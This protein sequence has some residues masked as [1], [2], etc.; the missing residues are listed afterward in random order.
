[1]KA[2]APS[3]AAIAAFEWRTATRRLPFAAAALLMGLMGFA[4]SATAFGPPELLLNGAWSV[5]SSVGFLTLVSVFAA[6]LLT[7]PVLLR[8]EE[9]RMAEIVYTTAVTKRGYLLGRFAGALLATAT[10]VLVGV[11]G[12]AAG[13]F[14][15]PHDPARLAPF[16][17][18]PYLWAFAVLALP[19]VLLVSACL[20]AVAALTRSTPATYV[21][22]VLL[23]LLYFV[24]ALLADSP[25]LAGSGPQSAGAASLAALL[26]PFGLS[27]FLSDTRFWTVAERNERLV[28]LAGTFLGSRLVGLGA[29]G[30][31][32]TVAYRRFAF[33]LAPGAGRV[34]ADAGPE[35]SDGPRAPSPGAVTTTPGLAAFGSTL[36]VELRALFRSAPLAALFALWIGYLAIETVQSFRSNELGTAVIPTAGLLVADVATALNVLGILFLVFFA[37]ETAWRERLVRVSEVVDATPASSALVLLGK[38]GALSAVLVAL[39]ASGLATALAFQAVVGRFE[40]APLTWAALLPVA[41]LPLVLLAL[42]VLLVQALVPNRH[43]GLALSVALIAFLHEGALGGPDHPLLRYAYAPR[44]TWS[45]LS[46]LSP[47]AESL[48]WF[49]AF[50]S[51]VAALLGVVTFGLW[52]RGTD[53]RLAPRLAALPRRWGRGGRLGAIA[54]ATL[55]LAVGGFAFHGT[56]VANRYETEA[57]L[58]AWKAAYERSYRPIEARAQP[59]PAHLDA[60][61]DLEPEARRLRVRGRLRLENRTPAA[62]DSVWVAARRDV[63]VASMTL[64]GAVPSDVDE[65]FATRRFAL[66]SPM[67]PG[68]ALDLAFDLLLER[69]SPSAADDADLVPN[70]TYV[71]GLAALPT[72]G[73]R[74]SWE[75]SDP[76]A[77]RRA[78]L[79]ERAVDDDPDAHLPESPSRMTFDV[80]VTTPA[81]QHAVA[82]GA[83]VSSTVAG[84]RRTSRFRAAR[85]VSAYFAFAS[86]RYHVERVRHV[87]VDVEVYVHP[88]HRRNVARVLEAAT[89]T[90][91]LCVARYG[92]Y[93][94]PQLRIAEVPDASLRA[95]GFALPGVV[96]LAERRGFLIDA[97]APGRV[98]L[99]AKRVAHEVS[100]Q[101]WGH[102]LDPAS[103]P[104]ATALVESLARHTELRV[105]KS[106]RGAEALRPVLDHE[107]DRYLT[108][109]TAGGEVPLVE[110]GR[111]PWLYYAKGSL[112]M[113]AISELAGEEA[114]D[115]ALGGL[116]A[117]AETTGRAP[118]ARDLV[119]RLLAATPAADRPLVEEWWTRSVLHDLRITE[120][121]ATRLPDGRYRVDVAVDGRTV[122]A[123][124]GAEKERPFGGDVELVVR[125]ARSDGGDDEAPP[126]HSARH[127]VRGPARLSVLVDGR[128]GEVLLDP[129]RLLLDRDRADDARDVE[130]RR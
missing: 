28:P 123:T 13:T 14:L 108:G 62:I 21:A 113:A 4:L 85:P 5:T 100:H 22:G 30:L 120:A 39:A 60:A 98:D 35:R 1:M 52:P 69:R 107:L 6:I 31:A 105:L 130:T 63:R 29:A 26:D 15:V 72:I 53:P 99:L 19:G 33:R 67:A 46:G 129:R 40:L 8:D 57:D 89:R 48:G 23:Y 86:A 3:A 84:D 114:V 27:A 77:R 91:D 51:A 50:W 71:H 124:E 115:G 88:G 43:V 37:A 87:G 24:A 76:A 16:A 61:F 128:P 93:P 81:N 104:G 92:P 118:T 59:M 2:K 34:A 9:H 68:A 121:I 102:Q 78:G 94:F 70:G 82:P 117:D 47:G 56:N 74:R 64:A 101:W 65:R 41:V 116:L 20:F 10:A 7:A 97:E 127:R 109:R 106:L 73:Y 90:L 12:L 32:L 110:V 119:A 49:A 25:L 112:A 45:D 125:A 36:R 44:L 54:C 111:Q 96:F 58:L 38:L 79:P 55:A 122:E 83:L 75:I 103:G 42:L 126:L 66:A 17:P 80:R 18:L 11:A 95:G